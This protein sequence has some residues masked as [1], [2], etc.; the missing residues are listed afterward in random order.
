M[1]GL[2]FLITQQHTN[3]RMRMNYQSNTLLTPH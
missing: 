1:N 3:A 2:A